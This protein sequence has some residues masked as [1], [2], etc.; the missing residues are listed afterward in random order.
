MTLHARSSL[1]QVHIAAVVPAYNVGAEIAAVLRSIPP[2]IRTIVVVDDASLDYTGAVIERC[3]AVDRRV[4]A[5]R[6]PK[7]RGVGAA[8]C[9]GF[10]T[11]IDAGADIIVKI[12]GD[13]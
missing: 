10:R 13:G 12:D 1:Q 4:I 11:A 9:T 7:N 2:I 6:H 8:M 5:V 3:A